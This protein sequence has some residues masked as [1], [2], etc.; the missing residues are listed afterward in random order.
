MIGSKLTSKGQ[1]TIPKEIR[2]YLGLQPGDRVVFLRKDGQVVLQ[3]VNETFLDLRGR[4]KARHRPE[5]FE[6]IRHQTKRRVAQKV[7]RD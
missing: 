3:G 4:V 7:A 1:T 5:D 6:H 2:E